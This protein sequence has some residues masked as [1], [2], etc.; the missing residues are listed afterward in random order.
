MDRIYKTINTDYIVT[1]IQKYGEYNEDD[2]NNI[3]KQL[4]SDIAY[5]TF[6]D[7]MNEF[8]REFHMPL[9]ELYNHFS[10]SCEYSLYLEHIYNY[11][12]HLIKQLI[13]NIILFLKYFI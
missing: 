6:I 4:S 9:K 13:I 3:V 8:K 5:N 12:K 11:I 10:G 7:P 2:I 1:Q